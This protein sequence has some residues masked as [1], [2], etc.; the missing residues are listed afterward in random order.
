MI[1]TNRLYKRTRPSRDANII[2]IFCDGAKREKDYFSYFNEIDSRIHLVIEPINKNEDISPKG[3]ISKAENKLKHDPHNKKHEQ[4][5]LKKNDEIWFVTDT[6]LDKRKARE[7]GLEELRKKCN[8]T[9]Q[10]HIAE[11]NPCFEVWLYYHFKDFIPALKNLNK[12]TYWKQH[13]SEVNDEGFDSRKHP[14]FIESAIHASKE[15][16]K[17]KRLTAGETEV[18]LLGEKI[19]SIVEKKINKCKK[20]I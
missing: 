3:L 12:C 14:I 20:N 17:N 19:F 13:M 15:N 8:D 4:I 6:D 1:L 7:K 18:Y 11:S 9:E 2:Y 10:W 5:K 16:H